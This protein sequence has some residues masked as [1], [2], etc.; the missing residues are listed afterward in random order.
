MKQPNKDTLRKQLAL[1][2]DTIIEL[3]SE[4]LARAA[5]DILC[6][7]ATLQPGPWWKFWGRG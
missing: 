2:A 1:A 5:F 7:R 4:Q 6:R 3:R